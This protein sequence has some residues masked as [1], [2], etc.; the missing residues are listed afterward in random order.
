MAKLWCC[1]GMLLEDVEIVACKPRLNR[2][3]SCWQQATPQSSAY[4][5]GTAFSFWATLLKRIDVMFG[6]RFNMAFTIQGLRWMGEGST[7]GLGLS[8]ICSCSIPENSVNSPKIIRKA[9][10]LSSRVILP[11][12]YTFVNLENSCSH[13]G[14][15]G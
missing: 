12:K 15:I 7:L 4:V 13:I 2:K 10:G 5:V 11:S 3:I 8:R 14:Q 6:D 1:R 9:L